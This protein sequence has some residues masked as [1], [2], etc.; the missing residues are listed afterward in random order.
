MN[1]HHPA[2]ICLKHLIFVL[3]DPLYA[4][5][6]DLEEGSGTEDHDTELLEGTH[7]RQTQYTRYQTAQDYSK[8]DYSRFT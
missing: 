1:S 5:M 6:M 7:D 8:D 2:W 4:R 3:T